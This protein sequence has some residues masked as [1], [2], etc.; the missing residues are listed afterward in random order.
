MTSIKG[1]KR[2]A[3]SLTVPVGQ[4]RAM[5]IAAQALDRAAPFGSGPE[6]VAAAVS[7]LGY[8][9]ID[10]I[11]V[12]E[13]SHHHI[14]FNRIPA[15]RRADLHSAQS[16]E[17]S[18]FEYWT[19]ALS[20][21]P[22]TD[23]RFF[24][25]TMKAHASDPAGWGGVVSPGE[26]G[27]IL[28]RI[29]DE[30][31]LAISDITDDTL[32]EK[33]HLWASKK[34]SKRALE[35]GFYSGRLVISRRDGMLKTYELTE[36]H[37]GLERL[38]RPASKS[39][40]DRYHLDRA[41]RAQGL[42]SLDSV[43]F[44]ATYAKPPVDKLAIAALI[45]KQVRARRLIELRL[46]NDD[47]T[48]YFARPEALDASLPEPV[49]THILSPFDP[50]VIQRKRTARIFGYE[51]LFEAYVPKA[52]RK[53]GYFTLPVLSG[54][55]IV[56]ALDLKAERVTKRLLIQAWHWVGMGNAAKHKEAV[57]AALD[58]FAAFQFADMT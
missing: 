12:I 32:V 23:L 13:R 19:H 10:T 53:L 20:Y 7:Q 4:A 16:V 56:A 6:A 46:A 39:D 37:F 54:D 24:T 26:L 47:R 44:N 35:A 11:N 36:R 49:L 8:V 21:V 50:L 17:R 31:A 25:G 9:Q 40:I 5:W 55:E 15:Y 22:V 2:V 43:C 48:A 3:A 30:G 51:H 45:G 33:A 28:R 14:L 1:E 57:D 18:V 42:V 41:L 34:P 58:R 52:K 27:K 29:R 38:P